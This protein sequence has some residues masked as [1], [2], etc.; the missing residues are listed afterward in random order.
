MEHE[1]SGDEENSGAFHR[2]RSR[3]GSNKEVPYVSDLAK[4]YKDF[5][6]TSFH[7]RREPKRAIR[8]RHQKNYLMGFN[9]K[10]YESLFQEI[11]T[12]IL[13][14]FPPTNEFTITK[15]KF[16]TKIPSQLK[17]LISKQIAGLQEESIKE[18]GG[19]A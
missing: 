17:N 5:L 9:A 13:E 14:G 11:W 15:G 6:E 3:R 1:T 16:V 4:Y 19:K 18:I 2:G 7:K 10:K 12:T 8:Y